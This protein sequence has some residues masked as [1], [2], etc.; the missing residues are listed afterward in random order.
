[1]NLPS[2]LFDGNANIQVFLCQPNKEIISEILPYD[3]NATFKFNTYSEINFT[4]DKHYNDL[5]EGTTKIY[6]YYAKVESLRVIYLRGIGH[7]VIQDVQENEADSYTKTVTCFSLEYSTGQKYLENFYVNT[8]EE[9]SV[10][11]M[12]H[13][14][15][16]GAEYS[17]DNYYKLNTDELFSL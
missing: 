8:G 4:I 9:G 17:I 6:P 1:M 11:T 10:E 16:Y 13:A 3:F 7:F 12:Y 15:K 14:Q 2:K 5:F